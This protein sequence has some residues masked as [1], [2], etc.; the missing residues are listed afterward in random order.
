MPLRERKVLKKNS[1]MVFFVTPIRFPLRSSG[2]SIPRSLLATTS[3]MSVEEIA[4][5]AR[6]SGLLKPCKARTNPE[7]VATSTLSDIN[8]FTA[9][10][11]V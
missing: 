11:P 5:M 9:K 4:A 8:P 7:A 6:R 2:F 1:A 3:T 10:A